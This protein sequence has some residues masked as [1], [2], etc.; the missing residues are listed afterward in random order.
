AIRAQRVVIRKSLIYGNHGWG[1]EILSSTPNFSIENTYILKNGNADTGGVN[2]S[3]SGSTTA[4][5]IFNTVDGAAPPTGLGIKCDGTPIS[6]DDSLVPLDVITTA[7]P[8]TCHLGEGTVGQ[9]TGGIPRN[10][11]QI[12][13]DWVH[14]EATAM[15]CGGFHINLDSTKN[16]EAM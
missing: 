11:N 4:R 3:Q 13:V 15:P 9:N 12:F 2:L 14:P 10:P 16:A 5:F 8:N 6:I 1:I 7:A